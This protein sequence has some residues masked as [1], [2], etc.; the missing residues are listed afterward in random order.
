[1]S[2][3]RLPKGALITFEGGDWSGKTTQARR[4]VEWLE[5]ADIPCV[6]SREP[7]GTE[8]GEEIRTIL[9]NPDHAPMSPKTELFLYM[10]N[11]AQHTSQLIIPALDA[12]SIVVCERFSD[13]TFAYQGAGRGIDKNVIEPINT[14]AT[15][16]IVPDL[17]I[18]I[19]VP[20]DESTER[21]THAGR[22]EDRIEREGLTFQ[23][24]V[25]QEY[26]RI[27]QQDPERVKIVDGAKEIDHI[28]Q[29]IIG[30]V[31]QFLRD[32]GFLPDTD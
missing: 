5:K 2:G 19:D 23:K 24:K 3:S 4:L 17:T 32:R 11:R 1:M 14:I 13:A 22:G 31:E 21:A 25:R 6:F 7:G 26:L 9:L 30:I 20:P 10:A 27:A 16:G 28:A 12:G 18:I 8:I 29:E 15:S